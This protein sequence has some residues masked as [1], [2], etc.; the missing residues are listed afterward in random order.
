MTNLLAEAKTFMSQQSNVW[1]DCCANVLDFVY[2]VRTG[3]TP[4]LYSTDKRVDDTSDS[5]NNCRMR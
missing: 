3:S 4:M 1:M 2:H 5:P